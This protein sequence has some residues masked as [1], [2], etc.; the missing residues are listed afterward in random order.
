M[1]G[2]LVV[3][4]KQPAPG[5]VKTRLCPP[6]S[7]EQAA[8]FYACMLEDALELLPVMWGAGSPATVTRS[9]LH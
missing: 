9:W 1:K 2:A 5:Q 3:F 4:A 6:F 8:R 7:P